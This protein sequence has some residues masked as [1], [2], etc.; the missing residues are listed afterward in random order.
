MVLMDSAIR[1]SLRRNPIQTRGLLR[2][3]VADEGV[4]LPD[5]SLVEKGMWLA[6]PVQAVQTGGHFYD[7]PKEYDPLRFARLRMEEAV[8][9]KLGPESTDVTDDFFGWSYGRHAWSVVPLLLYLVL[10]IKF[11]IDTKHFHRLT[12]SSPGR[13]FAVQNLKLM[14]A[15][16]V[17]NFDIEPI[18]QRPTSTGIGDAN[19]PSLTCRMKVRRK[20]RT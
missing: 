18:D 3:V 14:I 6:L 9:P 1:E 7:K 4:W 16:I 11:M 5:G 13:W 8:G 10:I 19:I 20:L 15:H 2:T 17:L 12:K